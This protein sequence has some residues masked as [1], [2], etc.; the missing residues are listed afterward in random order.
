[1]GGDPVQ[2]EDE[3]GRLGQAGG[4]HSPIPGMREEVNCAES[5]PQ[6]HSSKPSLR[7]LLIE[8]GIEPN[9]LLMPAL[10]RYTSLRRVLALQ[11]WDKG[12]I[13]GEPKAQNCPR[14]YHDDEIPVDETRC[15]T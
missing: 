10:Q 15:P 1:M 11:D 8:G 13:I 5:R 6:S 7:R 4:K 12:Q 2:D 3:G 14:F 9:P